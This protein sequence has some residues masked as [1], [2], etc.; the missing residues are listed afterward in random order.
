LKARGG[1][2]AIEKTCEEVN[3]R[4]KA[5]ATAKTDGGSAERGESVMHADCAETSERGDKHAENTR[6]QETGPAVVDIVVEVAE[7]LKDLAEHERDKKKGKAEGGDSEKDTEGRD[8]REPT[9]HDDL[10]DLRQVYIT[11]R[12]RSIG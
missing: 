3:H 4:G 7:M 5:D 1:L 2:L 6:A 11:Q 8:F 12:A 10:L 9:R